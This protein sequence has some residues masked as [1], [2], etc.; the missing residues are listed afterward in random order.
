MR[1]AAEVYAPDQSGQWH[2]PQCHS[3]DYHKGSSYD[4]P[5]EASGNKE[6]AAVYYFSSPEIL[7]YRGLL[8]E[9]RGSR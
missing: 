4:Y 8:C 9:L 3:Q 6:K 5:G 7:K 1:G 2:L